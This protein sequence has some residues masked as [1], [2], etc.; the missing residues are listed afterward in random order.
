MERDKKNNLKEPQ[1]KNLAPISTNVKKDKPGNK[2]NPSYA[3]AKTNDA[4]GNKPDES[5]IK[6]DDKT[7]QNQTSRQ[8]FSSKEKG[9]NTEKK[10]TNDES[11]YPDIE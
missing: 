4:K 8:V 6:Q 1:S 2:N 10:I 11:D 3:S 7:A 5:P 9:L